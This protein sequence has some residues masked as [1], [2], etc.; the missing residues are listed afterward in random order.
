MDK[1]EAL[2]E[3]VAQD[4]VGFLIE[5]EG[6]S[7]PQALDR[8]YGSE[9]AQRVFDHETGLYREGAAYVYGLL[10][11]ELAHGRIVQLEV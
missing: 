11:D 3:G 6:L 4:V 8:F 10:R 9:V 7:V 5:D 2:A 1:P